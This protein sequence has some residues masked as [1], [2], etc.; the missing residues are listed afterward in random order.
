MKRLKVNMQ[1]DEWHEW[2]ADLKSLEEFSI[3]RCIKSEKLGST[4]S[5]QLHHFADASEDGYATASY[6]LLT[7]L[8]NKKHCSLLIGKSRVTPLKHVTIPRLELTAAV[9]A[10]KMDKMEC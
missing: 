4:Q 10:V 3:P 5:A 7:S 9:L 1:K 6:I 8:E 2:L